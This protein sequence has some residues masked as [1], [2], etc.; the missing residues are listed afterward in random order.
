[1]RTEQVE[2]LPAGSDDDATRIMMARRVLG[3]SPMLLATMRAHAHSLSPPGAGVAS[4]LSVE[5][6]V[7][8]TRG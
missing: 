2:P 8:T 6:P 4:A 5:G 7:D 1:M 3:A